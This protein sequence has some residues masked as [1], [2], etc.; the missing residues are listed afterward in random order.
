VCST[1]SRSR[2]ILIAATIL[3]IAAGQ[4]GATAI[5]STFGPGDSYAANGQGMASGW[6]I[7]FPFSFGGPQSYLFDSVE[8]AVGLY[9]GPN[10]LNLSLRTDAAGVP[11]AVLESFSFTDQMVLYQSGSSILMGAS[12]SHPL[13]SPGTNYWLVGSGASNGDPVWSFSSL[14]ITGTMVGSN[15]GSW[16]SVANWQMGAF[17]I[18]G[19]DNAAPIPAPGAILLGTL[20][21]GL[22]GWLRRRRTL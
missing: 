19:M 21:A 4:A 18:N 17:R 16:M 7:G 22:V 14:G 6:A 2:I 20:G 15:G 5:F 13:L 9:Y 1:H 11:G 3:F 10:Q 8:L 12:V